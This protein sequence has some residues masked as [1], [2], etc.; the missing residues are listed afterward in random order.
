M[1]AKLCCTGCSNIV[2]KPPSPTNL[3]AEEHDV[4]P[5]AVPLETSTTI[6]NVNSA[7]AQVEAENGDDIPDELDTKV[8]NN[9]EEKPNTKVADNGGNIPEDLDT[10]VPDK[11][12]D[13]PEDLKTKATD[14]GEDILEDLDTNAS[15][16]ENNI[17]DHLHPK[18]L[19]LADAKTPEISKVAVGEV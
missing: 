17:G 6:A 12:N 7:P 2:Q 3:L 4:E 18:S 9:E 15:E 5:R 14:N 8:T 10:K 16:R 1:G 11:C 13:I 19:N